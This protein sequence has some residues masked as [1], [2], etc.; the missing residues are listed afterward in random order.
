M[1]K[2][3][4]IAND[5]VPGCDLPVA[6]PGIR[7][8]GIFQ[9]LRAHGYDA[10]IV[11]P[12]KQLNRVNRMT[13]RKILTG[14]EGILYIDFNSLADFINEQSPDACIICN[15][16]RYG[17]L[18]APGKNTLNDS[19][20]VIYDFFAPKLLELI[21]D[22][23]TYPA[24]Q[25]VELKKRK[26]LTLEKSHG[27]IV[28]GPKKIPYV[29]ALLLDLNKDFR[30]IPVKNVWTGVGIDRQQNYK[31]Q[32][33]LNLIIS[34]YTH[35][36]DQTDKDAMDSYL[37]SSNEIHL[38][39][40]QPHHWGENIE[41]VYESNRIR[42]ERNVTRYTILSYEGFIKMLLEMH[43]SVDLFERNLERE[44]STA[45]RT[46]VSLAAGLPVIHPAYTE[47]SPLIREYDAG[48]LYERPDEIPHIL[49][50]IISNP[51]I[52]AKKHKNVRKLSENIF[53]PEITVR[54]LVEILET[55]LV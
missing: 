19:I 9:G 18:F 39:L 55:C 47:L 11:A 14:V 21:Y 31:P 52:L 15:S 42:T 5:V 2:I 49:E 50:G 12:I 8:Y 53:L 6:G 23:S 3:F 30:S 38:H 28:N 1:K 4:L 7:A 22:S 33:P 10:W 48:W 45:T 43:L 51:S 46:I 16:N 26:I 44:Y 32:T 17:D 36:W 25:I 29:L 13:F 34:G 37:S 40:I 20:K 24:E 27:I 54:P 41:G 35:G